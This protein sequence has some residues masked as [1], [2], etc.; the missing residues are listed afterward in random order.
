MPFKLVLTQRGVPDIKDVGENIFFQNLPTEYKVYAFYYSGSTL[1]EKLEDRLRELGETTGG[2][3]LVNIGRLNDPHY[4][5]IVEQFDIKQ[6]PVI[7]V[8]GMDVLAS[9][10]DEYRTAFARLDS[11]YLLS[12]PDRTVQCVERLYNLFLQGKVSDAIS[13]AKSSERRAIVSSLTSCL[14]DGL[15]GLAGFVAE[16]DISVSLA[17]GKFELKKTGN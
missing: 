3:L 13:Q 1:N 17:E 6:Y 2:N 10:P 9:T 15:K 16:R 8:T 11:K 4:S 5:K 7:V 12:S 14:V